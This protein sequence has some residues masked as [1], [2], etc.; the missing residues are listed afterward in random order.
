MNEL[1]ASYYAILQHIL[2]EVY[3]V[4]HLIFVF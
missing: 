4:V 3:K 2:G 1:V